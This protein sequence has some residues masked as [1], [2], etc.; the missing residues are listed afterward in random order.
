MVSLLH[1]AIFPGIPSEMAGNEGDP[2]NLF[3]RLLWCKIY[4]LA[5]ACPGTLGLSQTGLPGT[6]DRLRPVGDLQLAEDVG[7]V[8]ADRLGAKR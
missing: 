1:W 4:D 6:D 8:I 3:G 7:D 5:L 2:P